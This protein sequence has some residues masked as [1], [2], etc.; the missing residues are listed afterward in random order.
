M[1][2]HLLLEHLPPLPDKDAAK[3]RFLCYKKLQLFPKKPGEFKF[4]GSQPVSLE[5]KSLETLAAEVRASPEEDVYY[6]AEK[7]DGMRW[8]M[9]IQPEGKQSFMI[10]RHFKFRCLPQ[11]MQFPSLVKGKFIDSTLLDGELVIDTDLNTGEQSLRY[12]I[13]DA[14]V[15][16]GDLVTQE[17]LLLRLGAVQ[18]ELL[19]PL[20]QSEAASGPQG[21]H[22]GPSGTDWGPPAHLFR[23]VLTTCEK[24]IR[25]RHA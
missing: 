1:Q 20:F 13:Y 10:D 6:V 18:R 16:N 24:G 4:P 3:L 7:T 21:G 14:C 25:W 5:Q 17:H 22:D 11:A 8:M 23:G 19:L 12:L 15:V 9:M 2:T